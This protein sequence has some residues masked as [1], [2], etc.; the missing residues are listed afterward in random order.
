MCFEILGFDVIIDSRRKT[1]NGQPQPYLLEVNHAPS[2]NSDTNLDKQ[3]KKDLLTDT[4]RL[5]NVS[6]DQKNKLLDILRQ[7]N[8]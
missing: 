7:V 2:F 3:V 1:P 4:F 6:M 5:L 8:E